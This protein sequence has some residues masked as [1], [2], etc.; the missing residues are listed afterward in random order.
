[1]STGPR[2]GTSWLPG[3]GEYRSHGIVIIRVGEVGCVVEVVTGP[4]VVVW[5]QVRGRVGSEGRKVVGGKRSEVVAVVVREVNG[6]VA[7]DA[8]VIAAVVVRQV[9]VVIVVLAIGRLE[10]VGAQSSG[11]GPKTILVV[12]TAGVHAVAQ[13]MTPWTF[14]QR[15][16]RR[17]EGKLQ[18]ALLAVQGLVEGG[19]ST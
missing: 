13:D 8:I 1:M 12:T 6:T 10:V 4:V 5:S 3:D 17:A 7:T 18:G 14:R 16:R 15:R 9:V 19:G 2:G 11:S